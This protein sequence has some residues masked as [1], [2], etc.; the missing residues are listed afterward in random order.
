MPDKPFKTYDQLID[1]LNSR[2][3]EITTDED[4]NY[5]KTVLSKE[6]YYN[7]INGYNKLFLDPSAGENQ[8]IKGTTLYEIHALYQFDR[9]LRDIFFKY[10]LRVETHIKN[11]I[12]YYFP[13]RYGHSNYLLYV[14]FNTSC[15]DAQSKITALIAEIQKQIASRA[16]DPSIS[17]YL[18]VYG[19]IPLWVLNNILTLGTISKF[20]S[21]MKTPERQDISRTFG[22]LDNELESELMYLSSVRNFCA[23]G[24]RLYC[25]R[26]K[27]P[28]IDTPYHAALSLTKNNKNEYIQGKRDLFAALIALRRLLSKNDYKRMSKDLH[29]A[30]KNLTQKLHILKSDDV[31][32]EM[33]FPSNWEELSSLPK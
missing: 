8:Y 16:S 12:A 17:H 20:Y 7:L 3:L 32:N 19:Y 27:N 22:I 24:N 15:R 28:L 1:I 2:G 9:V 21:L 11:L 4:K 31:L 10:I 25:Y 14:N 13:M 26:T 18:N 23:H 5:A 33:G 29:I 6:G 30:I